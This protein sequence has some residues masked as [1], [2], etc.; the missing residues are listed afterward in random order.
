MANGKD[1][2]DFD[3][4]SL[5]LD[6]MR[7]NISNPPVNINAAYGKMCGDVKPVG[8]EILDFRNLNKTKR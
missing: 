5:W 6:D 2:R 3:F 4:Y 8:K 7:R 1:D